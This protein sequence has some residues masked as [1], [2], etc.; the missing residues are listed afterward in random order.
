[1]WSK[2]LKYVSNSYLHP[3]IV[4][5]FRVPFLFRVLHPCRDGGHGGGVHCSVSLRC[6]TELNARHAGGRLAWGSV[7]VEFV[8]VRIRYIP[9]YLLFFTNIIIITATV[10]AINTKIIISIY[11]NFGSAFSTNRGRLDRL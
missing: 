7:D 6:D 11:L 1:L 3:P 10:I 2:T 9:L 4:V 8:C 5:F